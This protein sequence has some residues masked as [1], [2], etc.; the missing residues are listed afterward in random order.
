LLIIGGIGIAF[1]LALLRALALDEVRG[2]IQRRVEASVEATISSLPSE[3]QEEWA[4]E[5]RAELAA[6]KS[7]PLSAVAFAR[8]L[9]QTALQLPGASELSPARARPA[10]NQWSPGKR[11]GQVA[12]RFSTKRAFYALEDL[13]DRW[14][15]W[16]S[17]VGLAL[18]VLTKAL[19]GFGVVM[20]VVL[21]VFVLFVNLIFIGER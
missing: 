20:A 10:S 18:V 16:I 12:S 5:W 6:M 1:L 13:G 2:R 17:P 4:D 3:L 15:P 8:G 11:I 14:F 9:R 19:I 7:M 21:G